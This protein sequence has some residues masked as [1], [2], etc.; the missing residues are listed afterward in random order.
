M[1]RRTGG[2]KPQEAWNQMAE[3]RRGTPHDKAAPGAFTTGP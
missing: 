3:S 1:L 2:G